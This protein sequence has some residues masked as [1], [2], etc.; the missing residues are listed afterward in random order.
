MGIVPMKTRESKS[1]ICFIKQTINKM[2]SKFTVKTTLLTL[3]KI[4]LVITMMK[5]NLSWINTVYTTNLTHSGKRIAN[6]ST[7]Q[8]ISLLK[9]KT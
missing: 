3:S 6:M 9:E 2:N 4:K 1:M 5:A 7:L 8:T